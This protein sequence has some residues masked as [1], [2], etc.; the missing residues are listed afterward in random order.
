[1]FWLRCSKALERVFEGDYCMLRDAWDEQCWKW[2]SQTKRF[3]RCWLLLKILS[4]QWVHRGRTR[5]PLRPGSIL[6]REARKTE[7][8]RVSKLRQ[9]RFSGVHCDIS[10][11]KMAPLLYSS[12]LGGGLKLLT[13]LDRSRLSKFH[14]FVKVYQS[15]RKYTTRSSPLGIDLPIGIKWQHA[16]CV[17][18]LKWR[19]QC[20]LV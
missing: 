13:Q 11:L 6:R 12:G 9:R 7:T 18:I 3:I 16:K 15:E 4:T 17:R 14:P 10:M 20:H 19:W 2:Y 1:M 8:F 5:V